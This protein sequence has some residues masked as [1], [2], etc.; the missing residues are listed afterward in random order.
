MPIKVESKGNNSIRREFTKRKLQTVLIKETTVPLTVFLM[1]LFSFNN[2]EL[3]PCP[4]SRAGQTYVSAD[5]PSASWQR[6]RR[7][8]MH[9]KVGPHLLL[10]LKMLLSLSPAQ[11]LMSY[12][13]P[14][15]GGTVF[16]LPLHHAAISL[17]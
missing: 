12:N 16:D 2:P 5:D 13:E 3:P 1:D 11:A 14:W 4:G 15:H 8:V 9:K 6:V 10:T 7:A 17:P